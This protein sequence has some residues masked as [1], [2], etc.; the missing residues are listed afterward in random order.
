[1]HSDVILSKSNTG[2]LEISE[3][4]FEGNTYFETEFLLE[5][6][7]SKAT[8][9]SIPNKILMTYHNESKKNQLIR[10]IFTDQLYNSLAQFNNEFKYFNKEI[11]EN[12]AKS[13][14]DLY[15]INGFHYANVTYSFKSQ[16]NN[17][18]NVLT[19]YIDEKKQYTLA[20]GITY[21]GIDVLVPEVKRRFEAL[22]KIKAGDVFNE[23]DIENEIKT[24]NNL[25]LRTGYM[26]SKWDFPPNVYV[27][28][29]NFNDSVVVNFNLGE[30]IKIG[31]IIFVDSTLGQQVLA[32]TTKQK[33]MRFTEGEYYNQF[34]MERS[35]DNLLSTGIFETVV[36]D[37][38]AKEYP[39]DDFV[40]DFVITSR[41][42]SLRDWDGGLTYNKT[43]VDKF[44]NFG[45][46]G[47]IFHRNLFGSA[48]LVN[49]YGKI[50]LKDVEHTISNIT[51]P[52]ME[53]KIGFSFSQPILWQFESIKENT[54]A[55]TRV[56]F[57]TY[58]EYSWELLNGLFNISKISFPLIFPVR[59][60]R[61]KYF[62]NANV[63]FIIS[64]EV[65]VNYSAVVN[66]A[67]DIAENSQDTNNIL[68]SLNL[69]GKINNYLNESQQYRLTSN[70]LS[71]SIMGD[72]R[73]NVFSTTTGSMTYFGI[74][75]F[76][77]IVF[78]STALSGGAKY[79]RMQ[80]IHTHFWKLSKTSVVGI[81]GKFGHTIVFNEESSFVPQDRQ[82]FAGGANSVRAWHARNLRYLPVD[83]LPQGTITNFS[84]NYIGSKT[85]IDGSIELRRKLNDIPGLSEN[86]S[87]LLNGMGLGV[88][89]DFGN[90]F[91]WYSEE[92]DTKTK[93]NFSDYITK[94]AVGTG[95]GLRYET[96]IGAI[97]LDIATPLYDPS[98]LRN[99]FGDI[100]FVFGI[101]HAF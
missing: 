17:K 101:G 78:Y 82:F 88:F 2:E 45:I 7:I 69:Y 5:Y 57:S 36:I 67:L 4:S 86:L 93:I 50:T 95:V 3:I 63:E 34:R 24:V 94:L 71:L 87:F 83:T 52:D 42:R 32:N 15:N 80:A 23:E 99:A 12:D 46:E 55:S 56:A 9:L 65:P 81:K 68:S 10:K 53:F 33:F 75:G 73:D 89:V 8:K 6:I 70:L 61:D 91:G 11:V 35:I 29:I 30:R 41:Y 92:G 51:V 66:N 21:K 74:D 64:R 39:K 85:L 19:F 48:Q 16:A 31:K 62:S 22:T 47:K 96:P 72:S 14:I 97:R 59:L 44:L 37:T 40:R 38:V 79:V 100:T 25:F 18:G 13:L 84:K 1:M 49:L 28:S 54:R 76:N 26:H 60:P 90:T 77:P 27:D 43:Q 98:G 58:L 20:S